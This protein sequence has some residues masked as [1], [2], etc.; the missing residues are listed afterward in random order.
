M[1]SG[2]SNE[3]YPRESHPLQCGRKVINS[4][5]NLQTHVP[6][7]MSRYFQK[8]R[9]SKL[10]PEKLK[11]GKNKEP[12]ICLS[13]SFYVVYLCA[14]C[15]VKTSC[16]QV[17]CWHPLQVTK[18]EDPEAEK[19]PTHTGMTEFLALSHERL[20]CTPRERNVVELSRTENELVVI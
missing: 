9:A 19:I 6:R 13:V 14:S 1:T 15:C 5:L 8:P 4:C 7:K 10:L 17:K 11:H 18:F 3:Q 12:R 16:V 20:C 2:L